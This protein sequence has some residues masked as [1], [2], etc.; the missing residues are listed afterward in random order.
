M[1]AVEDTVCL[2]F[3]FSTQGN[4]EM[5]RTP[6][7]ASTSSANKQ[8]SEKETLQVCDSD[9]PSVGMALT[10]LPS[11][12]QTYCRIRP[13]IQ[14]FSGYLE[15]ESDTRVRLKPNF[16]SP[17]TIL[18]RPP[19]DLVPACTRHR[20]NNPAATSSTES[21]HPPSLRPSSSRKRLCLWS[22]R[23]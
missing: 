21:S 18:H 10:R 13:G 20:T 7:F 4:G 16:V 23:R 22:S 9:S 12:S 19:A 11:L 5:S 8:G 14:A 3:R 2:H 15:I 17:P 6:S 1:K